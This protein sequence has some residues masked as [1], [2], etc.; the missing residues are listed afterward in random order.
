VNDRPARDLDWYLDQPYETVVE[1]QDCGGVPC[2][3]ARNPE[4]RGCMSHGS[5]P[6][7]AIRNLAEARHLYLE[8]LLDHGLVP[9]LPARGVTASVT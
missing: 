3:L 8:T 4:L 1:T 9:P 2:Y 5:T 6:E 7:E